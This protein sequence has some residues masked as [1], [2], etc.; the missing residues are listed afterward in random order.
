MATGNGPVTL[1]S[2]E[3]TRPS[4]TVALWLFKI[5]SRHCKPTTKLAYDF[6]ASFWVFNLVKLTIRPTLWTL[7]YFRNLNNNN[8]SI[9]SGIRDPD[10]GAEPSSGA[11]PGEGRGD[12]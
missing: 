6:D 4:V 8:P 7:W 11:G 1:F 3:A 5:L 12:H 9:F 2:R 10:E